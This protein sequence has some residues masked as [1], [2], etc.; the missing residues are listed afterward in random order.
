MDLLIFLLKE[1]V[2]LFIGHQ[3][4]LER[5]DLIFLKGLEFPQLSNLIL[6]FQF[7][8]SYSL[9]IG[10][11]G[12]DKMPQLNIFLLDTPPIIFFLLFD[13]FFNFGQLGFIFGFLQEIFDCSLIISL[14]LSYVL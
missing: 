13:G 9:Q 1:G 14:Q 7:L 4:F 3:S 12:I 5:V 8:E 6:K 10:L 11:L 2:C